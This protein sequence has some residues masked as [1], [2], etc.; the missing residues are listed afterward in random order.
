MRQ[1]LLPL[2]LSAA[3]A[4]CAEGGVSVSHTYLPQRGVPGHADYAAS[5][6]PTPVVVRNSE[7]PSPTVVAALQQNSSRR[8]LVFTTEPPSSLSQGYRV[9]VSFDDRPSG[10]LHV[11]REPLGAAPMT[12]GAAPRAATSVYGAFCLGPNLL[13]EAVVSAP[14]L[15][16][17]RDARLARVMGDL[18]S[19]IMPAHEL[20]D[21]TYRCYPRC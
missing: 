1:I 14:R 5:L 20:P 3:L 11:C 6:G 18:L 9:L 16:A 12:T 19:A 10:D 2:C 17:P 4:A 13:S 7:F 21:G 8:H 15:E